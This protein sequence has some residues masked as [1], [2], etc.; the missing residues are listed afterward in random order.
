MTYQVKFEKS[1]KAKSGNWLYRKTC[2]VDTVATKRCRDYLNILLN[3]SS[4]QSFNN[5]Q[6]FNLKKFFVKKKRDTKSNINYYCN[7]AF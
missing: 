3:S 5:H 4:I 1:R 2:C 6:G 7:L